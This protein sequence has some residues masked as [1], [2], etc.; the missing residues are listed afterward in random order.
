MTID[1]IK[2]AAVAE[3]LDPKRLIIYEPYSVPSGRRYRLEY[4]DDGDGRA[5]WTFNLAD[6]LFLDPAMCEDEI[7]LNV[8]QGMK[9]I[10]KTVSNVGM[11]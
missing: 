5:E 1:D 9:Q 10:K 2:A 6:C 7:V 4:V 3:G 11:V 8:T